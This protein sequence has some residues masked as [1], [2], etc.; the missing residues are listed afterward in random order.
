MAPQPEGDFQENLGRVPWV[1]TG[2]PP[3]G[4]RG[5]WNRPL[6]VSEVR[7]G[8]DEAFLAS[9]SCSSLPTPVRGTSLEWD[10]PSEVRTKEQ[11]S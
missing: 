9:A 2:G 3:G 6:K 5:S 10:F 1:G 11:G 7:E 4:G 8:M